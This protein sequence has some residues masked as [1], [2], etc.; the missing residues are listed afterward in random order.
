MRKKI[1]NSSRNMNYVTLKIEETDYQTLLTTKFVN[2]NP[3]VPYD[4][5]KIYSHI[6]GTVVKILAEKGETLDPGDAVVIIDAMKMMN[7]IILPEG[8]TIKNIYV[9]EGENIPKKH[10]I[11]DLK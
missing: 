5:K 3:Y 10:L 2:R 1:K 11:A 8:G 6:P 4:H 7:R 9:R